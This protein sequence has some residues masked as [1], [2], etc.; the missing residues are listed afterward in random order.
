MYKSSEIKSITITHGEGSSIYYVTLRD[1]W[2]V[3][4]VTKYYENG[5]KSMTGVGEGLEKWSN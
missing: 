1:V 2:G 5:D 3:W 4:R